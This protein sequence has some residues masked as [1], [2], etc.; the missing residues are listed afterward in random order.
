MVLGLMEKRF[1]GTMIE[2]K[3]P[4]TPKLCLLAKKWQE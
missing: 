1:D 2:E 4:V 3:T